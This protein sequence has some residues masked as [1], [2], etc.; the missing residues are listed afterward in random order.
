MI[1]DIYA[2]LSQTGAQI[3]DTTRAITLLDAPRRLGRFANAAV[4]QPLEADLRVIVHVRPSDIDIEKRRDVVS[5]LRLDTAGDVTLQSRD[6]VR[7]LAV[8]RRC[9]AGGWH[10]KEDEVVIVGEAHHQARIAR[11][12]RVVEKLAHRRRR[13]LEN[14]IQLFPT[15]DLLD[16]RVADEVEVQHDE[17]AAFLEEPPRPLDH[18]RKRWQTRH[19][20][21]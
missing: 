17:F 19:R 5:M 18:H 15:V 9:H 13:R 21:M 3:S 1:V 6:H 2:T 11:C 14:G 8:S 7:D 10:V 16:L 20:V 12:R 4:D